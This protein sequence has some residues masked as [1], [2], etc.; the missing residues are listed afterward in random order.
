MATAWLLP[1]IDLAKDRADRDLLAEWL[2]QQYVAGNWLPVRDKA[3]GALLIATARKPD[4]ES[5]ARISGIVEC[6]VEFA[7]ATAF[8]IRTAVERATRAKRMISFIR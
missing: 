2:P 8:D 4:A 1:A 5:T 6:P 3:N 7:V